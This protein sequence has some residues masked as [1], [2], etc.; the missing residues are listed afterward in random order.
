[1]NSK[2]YP[3]RSYTESHFHPEAD[4]HSYTQ[5]G[6]GQLFTV[7]PTRNYQGNWEKGE[8]FPTESFPVSVYAAGMLP[9][10]ASTTLCGN[11]NNSNQGSPVR[12]GF[13]KMSKTWWEDVVSCGIS[14]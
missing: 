4:S 1:M 10:S 2:Q 6:V 5:V 8:N 3:Y 13:L 11:D 9:S 12:V 7:H 14:Y